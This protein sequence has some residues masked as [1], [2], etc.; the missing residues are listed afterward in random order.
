MSNAIEFLESL[1]SAA[2]PMDAAHY[3]RAVN[4]LAIDPDLRQALLERDSA[5]INQLLGG[6]GSMMLVLAP[7]EDAPADDDGDEDEA[8]E[9]EIRAVAA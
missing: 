3:A 4:G 7:A 1:G 5:R 6:R 2:E 8:D 9:Q